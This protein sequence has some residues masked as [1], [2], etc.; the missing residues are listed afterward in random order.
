MGRPSLMQ[1][2]VDGAGE[3]LTRVRVGGEAIVVGEG[4]L[5]IGV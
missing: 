1:V 3:A 2:S 4:T 5:N